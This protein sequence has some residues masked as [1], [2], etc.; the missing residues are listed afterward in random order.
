LAQEELAVATRQR[1]CT[2]LCVCPRGA[3]KIKDHCFATPDLKQCDLFFFLH[4]KEKLC[5][6][7]FQSAKEIITAKRE[8]VQDLPA[9]IF[10]QC[11][12]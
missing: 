11:F 4:L 12:Q 7:R 5:G 3:K 8:A 6:H 9:N 2:L 10:Q 1:P